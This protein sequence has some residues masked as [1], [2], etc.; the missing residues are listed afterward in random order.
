MYCK[1]VAPNVR[2]GERLRQAAARGEAAAVTELLSRG[3]HPG[4]SDAAGYTA[5]HY[6]SQCGNLECLQQMSDKFGDT[7]DWD[8][9][10]KTG[11]SPLAVAAHAGHR[12]VVTY[13]LEIGADPCS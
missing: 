7:C 12:D 2:F 4:F 6:A 10:D 11:W 1:C 13:L 8:C 5:M 9:P 3:C